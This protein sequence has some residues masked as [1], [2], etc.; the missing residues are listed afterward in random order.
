[1]G[2]PVR[3]GP[4]PG[5][6]HGGGRVAGADQQGL[7][8]QQPNHR[9]CF[10]TTHSP[11]WCLIL[12]LTPRMLRIPWKEL[13]RAPLA[14]GPSFSIVWPRMKTNPAGVTCWG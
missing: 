8:Q 7:G 1:M 14:W 11:E 10:F 9:K 5:W 4:E 13:L 2:A 3:G 12:S 6:P